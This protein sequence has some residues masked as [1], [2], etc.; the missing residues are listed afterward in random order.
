MTQNWSRLE[1]D[2]LIFKLKQQWIDEQ[3]VKESFFKLF[4][5]DLENWFELEYILIKDLGMTVTDIDNM[6]YYRFQYLIENHKKRIEKE[7]ERQ[8]KEE[9]Q[10]GD[11]FNFNQM[12]REQQSQMKKQTP[13]FKMPSSSSFKMPTNFSSFK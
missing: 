6:E 1:T 5:I 2:R 10:T 8:E 12:A 7:K 4:Q 3:H 11:K 9:K 13:D